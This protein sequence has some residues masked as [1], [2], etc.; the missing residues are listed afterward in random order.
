MPD[1]GRDHAQREQLARAGA[2][3]LPQQPREDAPPDH[4]HQRDEARRPCASVERE[5]RARAPRADVDA[6]RR[7]SQPASGGSSTRTSTIA[8][9]STTS[10]PTAMRPLTESSRPR[11]SSARISTTVLATESASP[12]TT[13]APRLQPHER[14]ERHAERRGDRD[15]D[16]RA[17]HR[18]PAHLEQVVEREVQTDAEHQQHHADLGELAASSRSATKPGV[19]GPI[20]MPASR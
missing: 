17:R 5:R 18:D 4:Q 13:P 11:F 19:A 14:G 7:P 12:N 15:L 3:D 6:G 20:A 2:R 10:Q 1:R 16:H 9:S 8:R